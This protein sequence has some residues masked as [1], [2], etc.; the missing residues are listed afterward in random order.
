MV[1]KRGKPG[2]CPPKILESRPLTRDDLA[3]LNKPHTYKPNRVTEFRDSHHLV[4]RLVA[5]G[6]RN[7]EIL[8]RSGFSYQSLYRF[9]QDPAFQELVAQYRKVELDKY[10]HSRDE[11]AS[12]IFRNQIKAERKLADRL[13][14]EDEDRVSTRDLITIARDAADRTGYGKRNTQVNVNVGMASALERASAMSSRALTIDGG[15]LASPSARVV[16]PPA[17]SAQPAQQPRAPAVN[18][19]GL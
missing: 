14:D 12:L 18:R 13:D 9:N 4:A 16:S 1:L 11:Y 19:R 5:S 6:L 10:D 7:D 8:E 15:S 17:Q 3:V 2:G